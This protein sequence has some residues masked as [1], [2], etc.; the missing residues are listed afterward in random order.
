MGARPVRNADSAPAKGRVVANKS[1]TAMAWAIAGKSC[2]W[3]KNAKTPRLSQI[4]KH[5]YTGKDMNQDA[6]PPLSGDIHPKPPAHDPRA[7]ARWWNGLAVHTPPAWLHEEVARRMAQRLSWIKLQP[8]SWLHAQPSLGGWEIHDQLVQRY[9][10][11]T[12][13]I[14]EPSTQRL[15]R[16][17]QKLQ[18]SGLQSLNP[19]KAKPRWIGANAAAQPVDM[20]WANMQWH[21]HP[22]PI[23]LLSQ[24]HR[25]LNVQGFLMFSS[26][27]PDALIELRQL[28]QLMGWP[29]PAALWTDMHDAGDMLV[30][31][32]FAEP[33]MDMERITLSY[34]SAER[35]LAD[36]RSLGR[37]FHPQRFQAL[38][39][40]GWLQQWT[41]A[42]QE[43]WPRR[44]E[45]GQLLLTFEI[46]YGHAWRPPERHR[47]DATTRISLNEMKTLLKKPGQLGH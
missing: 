5:Q 25:T 18:V 38:R 33:V 4:P 46:V 17:Q 10:K 14:Q 31:T 36:L 29:E 2:K 16:S 37:N 28:H 22:D 9:P 30:Q 27:G 1:R 41:Q 7:C 24:W 6:A 3:T 8:Q 34:S 19:F 39:G 44:D 12:V 26:L 15:R 20:I 13:Y 11:A 45:N 43:H 35:M 21:L 40:K 42:A 47:V 32:G 23:S